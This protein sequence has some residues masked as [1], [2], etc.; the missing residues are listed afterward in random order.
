MEIP[1]NDKQRKQ[2]SGS[3]VM[4][5]KDQ[6]GE[7]FPLMLIRSNLSILFNS[8]RSKIREQVIDLVINTG[9]QI[10]IAAGLKQG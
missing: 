8:F 1:T 5:D 4:T 2:I 6:T 9:I 3:V 7:R 10:Q